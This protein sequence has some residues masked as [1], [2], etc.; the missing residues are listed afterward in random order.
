MATITGYTAARMKEIED[1]T[2][3]DGE[4]V[5]NNLIL[6]TREGTPID[7]GN[8]RG[9]QGIKGDPGDLVDEPYLDGKFY[10]RKAGAWAPLNDELAP[11]DGQK[12]VL[13]DGIW[14]RADRPWKIEFNNS[15]PTPP[16][17][18]TVGDL[19]EFANWYVRFSGAGY[20]VHYN[21]EFSIN[22]SDVSTAAR[23]TL[24][25]SLYPVVTD[26][27]VGNMTDPRFDHVF[28]QGIGIGRIDIDGKITF[29]REKP[30]VMTEASVTV[31]GDPI[32]SVYDVA[33]AVIVRM[34]GSY[35]RASDVPPS[36]ATLL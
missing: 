3:V 6:Q 4:V 26:V 20:L 32:V 19:T 31:G 21:F 28:T 9:P 13:K 15:G 27:V 22:G 14:V 5:G 10:G 18:F 1:T 2:V 34:A 30:G 17:G 23:F 29:P 35:I 16:V 25:A 12:Y 36:T 33:D 8:V 11:E 7:A 24:P